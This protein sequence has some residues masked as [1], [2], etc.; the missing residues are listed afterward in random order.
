MLKAFTSHL[1]ANNFPKGRSVLLA[2]SGG[3][4]SVVM[5]TLFHRLGHPFAIAHCNYKLRGRASE[6]DEQLVRQLADEWNVPIHIMQF[7]GLKN[8]KGLQEKARTL[9]YNWMEK[10]RTEHEYALICTA[11]HQDDSIETFLFHLSRG[12][13]LAGLHGIPVRNRHIF[14]PMLFAGRT[15]IAAFAHKHKLTFRHDGSNDSLDY[16]RNHI[17]NKLIPEFCRINPAFRKNMQQTMEHLREAEAVYKDAAWSLFNEIT[18]LKN[19]SILIDKRKWEAAAHREILLFEYLSAFGF[20]AAQAKAI[21]HMVHVQPGKIFRS[22]SHTLLNDRKYFM[23]SPIRK[24][25][26]AEGVQIREGFREIS[27]P[28]RMTFSFSDPGTRAPETAILDRDK[29]RFP[30][31]LRRW[32]AGDLFFPTGMKGRKKLS[33]FLTDRKVPRTEKQDIFVITSGRDIVWV[34]GLRVD[35]RFAASEPTTSFYSISLK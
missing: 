1:E 32:K 8:K 22:A 26:A 3:V 10:I 4:D 2:V 15:Q 20:N 35:R 12:T 24:E 34:V 28:C 23:L 21:A 30:L 18:S 25:N 11:H 5:A 6:T 19:E 7:P 13:G 9:R 31:I 16:S 17:R 29:L 27:E 33:D 14:R